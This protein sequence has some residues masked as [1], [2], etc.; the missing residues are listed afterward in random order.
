MGGA[1]ARIQPGKL[2][3]SDG[4]MHALQR[5]SHQT[6][7][8]R[9]TLMLHRARILDLAHLARKSSEGGDAPLD[10]WHAC[11]CG[12]PGL[13]TA[14]CPSSWRSAPSLR[15]S[16]TPP[17]RPHVS[18]SGNSRPLNASSS[19]R[20][21]QIP[22]NKRDLGFVQCPIPTGVSRLEVF[23]ARDVVFPSLRRNEHDDTIVHRR[24]RPPS[25]DLPGRER[26]LL[27][28]CPARP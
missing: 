6:P 4:N 2:R 28:F 5:P 27:S 12:P 8:T 15:S 16:I 24:T 18:S 19:A 11:S 3:V 25:S 7:E 14:S 1:H 20:N 23:L 22:S 9:T 21:I 26:R 17:P 13:R 10:P